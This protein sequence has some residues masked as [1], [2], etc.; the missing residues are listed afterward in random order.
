MSAM[1]KVERS[2][3]PEDST[4]FVTNKEN[5]QYKIFGDYINIKKYIAIV[6][7]CSESMD[8]YKLDGARSRFDVLKENAAKFINK[9]KNS[10]ETQICIFTY[11]DLAR[12]FKDF[13]RVD[14]DNN[15]VNR[16]AL[17]NAIN[18]LTSEKNSNLGDGMRKAYWKLK[19]LP[20]DGIKCILIMTDGEADMFT[21]ISEHS[22]YDFQS[23][24][25][26]IDFI[27]SNNDSS[28]VYDDYSTAVRYGQEMGKFITA[29]NIMTFAI[30][31][32]EEDSYKLEAVAASSG[33]SKKTNGKHYYHVQGLSDI[34]NV[35]NGIFEEINAD[36]PLTVSFLE[37][38]PKGIKVLTVPE[39]FELSFQEDGSYKV[40]G[41][42]PNVKLSKVDDL[43]NFAVNQE[44]VTIEIQYTEEG[45]K[46]F[47]GLKIGYNDRYGNPAIGEL[48]NN[49]VV[50]VFV[51]TT[52]PV[53]SCSLSGVTKDG[54]WY[55]SDIEVTLTAIDI[56]DETGV[57][58]IEYKLESEAWNVYEA[59]FI[60]STEGSN[61]LAFRAVD[62]AGNIEIEKFASLNIDKTA[63]VV[64][65]SLSGKEGDLD[66]WFASDVQVALT[67]ADKPEGNNSGVSRIEYK[68]ENEEWEEYIS[69]IMATS[70]G[71]NKL[72]SRA[73]DNVG[74]TSDEK[75]KEIQ[76]D[77]TGPI[78]SV[79][80]D[81]TYTASGDSVYLNNI[82]EAS[83]TDELSGVRSITNNSSKI[84]SVG[85]TEVIWT[86]VDNNGNQSCG[87]EYVTIKTPPIIIECQY[88]IKRVDESNYKIWF[89]PNDCSLVCASVYIA[90]GSKTELINNLTIK[91]N[92]W[93]Y[94]LKEIPLNTVIK[95]SFIYM[96]DGINTMTNT[97]SYMTK[98]NN[99]IESD[100]ADGVVNI[101]A[102]EAVIWFKTNGFNSESVK[103]C[104][105]I[106]SVYKE[107]YMTR[108]EKWEFQIGNLYNN[109]IINYYFIFT[110]S[111]NVNYKTPRKVYVH[112]RE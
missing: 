16:D 87:V 35:C 64:S 68:F 52:P 109:C 91:N 37:T 100:Y 88:D 11:S 10:P 53:T 5:I 12:Q 54:N 25:G 47:S 82:G 71:K 14:G 108:K 111:T 13:T 4:I 107:E 40:S 75:V 2:V 39:G 26:N 67:A 36:Y 6:I 93:E 15:S 8:Y 34:D 31:F 32:N 19:V 85:S 18:A 62:N 90:M 76:I 17:I 84:F 46:D 7:D 60:A 65:Y 57:S 94:D 70:E 106:D 104:Y 44:I 99:A 58:L 61:T 66:N 72:Y 42:I 59:P 48:I 78:I 89:K 51:D 3:I 97:K 81:L 9:F 28:N 101:S 29:E 96:K 50:E 80:P 102:T 73:I 86:A 30:G 45:T 79:P 1:M 83:A 63:P 56:N 43:G 33:A 77:K 21:T 24:E 38:V 20:N 110:K 41:E 23:L 74:N 49:L 92:V 22:Y 112:Y 55:S 95:Y 27:T 103:L 98:A 105:N 69:P